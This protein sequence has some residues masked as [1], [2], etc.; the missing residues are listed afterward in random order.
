MSN[1]GKRE[2]D[3]KYKLGGENYPVSNKDIDIDVD[4]WLKE[5]FDARSKKASKQVNIQSRDAKLSNKKQ[6]KKPT[7]EKSSKTK[8]TSSELAI[9]KRRVK[10]LIAAGVVT[11]GLGYGAYNIYKDYQDKQNTITTMDEALENGATLELLEIDQS[12]VD[13]INELEN[14]E[15]A[16]LDNKQLDKVVSKV[17]ELQKD[18]LKSKLSKTLGV[19]TSEIKLY[20]GNVRNDWGASVS[21]DGKCYDKPGLLNRDTTIP[22]EIAEYINVIAGMQNIANGNLKKD[23][24]IKKIEEAK[25]E[26]NKMAALGMGV[27]EKGNIY[28]VELKKVENKTPEIHVANINKE[29]TKDNDGWDR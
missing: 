27:D 12:I 19:E 10:A 28:T 9:L 24:V 6:I 26:I 15:L 18:T 1:K 20:P 25:A 29:N 7:V 5:V 14:I 22:N 3:A 23:E 4:P 11:L 8:W 21:A 16:N 13:R 2:F 17:I